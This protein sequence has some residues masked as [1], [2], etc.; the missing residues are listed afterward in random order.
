M[1]SDREFIK[2][3]SSILKHKFKQRR[4]VTEFSNSQTLVPATMALY[5]G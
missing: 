2:V 4:M 5:K 1:L 3:A